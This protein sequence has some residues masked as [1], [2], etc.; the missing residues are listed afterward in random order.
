MYSHHWFNCNYSSS[1]RGSA[2]STF[3]DMFACAAVW[4]V[5][6]LLICEQ[7]QS[8][9]RLNS[10]LFLWIFFVTRKKTNFITSQNCKYQIFFI[11]T[12]FQ[13]ISVSFYIEWNWHLK[14]FSFFWR[15]SHLLE[16]DSL[17]DG[18]HQV[19]PQVCSRGRHS[20]VGDLAKLN[21]PTLQWGQHFI[22]CSC[23]NTELLQW[24]RKKQEIF[25]TLDL[26]MWNLFLQ[27]M[28]HPKLSSVPFV[29]LNDLH[30]IKA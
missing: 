25:L 7:Q 10:L 9:P 16:G 12:P 21:L 5:N 27:L 23:S 14:I 20:G 3:I 28:K 22:H 6:V 18:R 4:L 1:M 24:W 29:S 17:S 30:L 19:A 11:K 2:V 15:E 8:P 13:N 26:G